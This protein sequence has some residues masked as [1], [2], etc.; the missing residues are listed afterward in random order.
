MKHEFNNRFC[1]T[2][3]ENKEA[4]HFCFM[5]PLANVPASSQHVLYV[6]YDFETTQDTKLSDRTNEHVPNLVCLQQFCSKRKNILDKEND[7]I[8][9]GKRIHSFWD[10]PVGD[11]LRYLCET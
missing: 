7:C 3:Y 9:C 2:C 4:G 6:F 8:Q 11:M 5:R 10:D 1:G